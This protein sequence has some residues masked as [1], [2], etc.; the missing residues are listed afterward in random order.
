MY[1]QQ[2][3]D[4]FVLM[5]KQI[6]QLHAFHSVQANFVIGAI[7]WVSQPTLVTRKGSLEKEERVE[8]RLQMD[9]T[10]IDMVTWGHW[11]HIVSHLTISTLPCVAIF[12]VYRLP[13]EGGGYKYLAFGET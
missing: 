4:A 11:A 9:N 10:A 5:W 13:Q 6:K 3:Y 2:Y 1:R 8:F 7:T 12:G